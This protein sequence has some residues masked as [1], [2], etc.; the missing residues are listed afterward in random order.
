MAD[1]KLSDLS[2][3]NSITFTDLIGISQD[4]GGEVYTNG[5]RKIT[6]ND[7]KEHTLSNVNSVLFST[8]YTPSV[9]STGLLHW[10]DDDKT[11]ELGM[12]GSDV[13]LQIG[14]ELHVYSRATEDIDNGEVVYVSGQQGNLRPKVTLANAASGVTSKIIGIATEDIASGA[15]GY[16]TVSGLV[17][18]VN[19]NGLGEGAVLYLDT[20]SGK[21]VTTPPTDAGSYVVKIGQVIVDSN[22]GSILVNTGLCFADLRVDDLTVYGSLFAKSNVTTKTTTYTVNSKDRVVLANAFSSDFTVNLP[23]SDDSEGVHVYIKKIDTS[24]NSIVIDPNGSETI[25]DELVQYVNVNGECIE[26]ICDG[27]QWRII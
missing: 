1:L 7:L 18:G 5:S 22:N 10:S 16:I 9:H 26:M 6:F 24:S 21:Y 25:D 11:L 20:T 3:S 2:Q 17:R 19:T 15:D 14:Q 13:F 8:D 27:S 12:E 4:Q 23:A